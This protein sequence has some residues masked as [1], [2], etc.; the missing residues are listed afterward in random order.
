MNDFTLKAWGILLSLP[1]VPVVLIYWFFGSQ[2]YFSLTDTAKGLV[3]SGPIA[4]YVVIV[5]MG[6]KI[7]SRMLKVLSKPDDL[8]MVKGNWTFI[9]TSSR[10]NE[11]GEPVND[12]RE[13]TC[14]FIEDRGT[15]KVCG[16]FLQKE[17]IVG[18]W[19]SEMC[20]I[21]SSMLKFSYILREIKSTSLQYFDGFCVLTFF[22]DQSI[23]G[24]QVNKMEGIWTIIGRSEMAGEITFQRSGVSL[25]ANSVKK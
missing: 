2:N 16:S 7:F 18:N 21:D 24:E 15:I 8:K 4:A 12:R 23:E 9:S 14:K 6:W 5:W 22:D 13:G 25:I 17:K 10:T 19:E 3:M 11:K 1:V 20:Q